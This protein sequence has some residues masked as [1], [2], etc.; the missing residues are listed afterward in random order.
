M[1]GR[2]RRDSQPLIYSDYYSNINFQDYTLFSLWVW[3]SLRTWSLPPL[4]CDS[5]QHQNS[6]S[7]GSNWDGSDPFHVHLPTCSGLLFQD[8]WTSGS[9][10][11]ATSAAWH[12]S[13]ANGPR[14]CTVTDDAQR[15]KVEELTD[16]GRL[17][18]G[19]LRADSCSG[20]PILSV[21]IVRAPVPLPTRCGA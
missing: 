19:R 16:A 4:W 2:V 13:Q 18:V 1:G 7:C 6:E 10:V 9:Q 15:L 11:K 21:P 8:F 20:L 14:S 12:Q 3:I 17:L 5:S